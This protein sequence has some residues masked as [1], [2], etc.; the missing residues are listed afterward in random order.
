MID[1][2]RARKHL[3]KGIALFA[4][5]AVLAVGPA[6]SQEPPPKPPEKHYQ[7]ARDALAKGDTDNAKS[8]RSSR[9]KTTRS[10]PQ[11]TSCWPAYS[12]CRERTTRRL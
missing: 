9:S 8:R 4:A 3:S 5:I 1:L 2:F 12:R 6:A 11:R 7:A 10:M